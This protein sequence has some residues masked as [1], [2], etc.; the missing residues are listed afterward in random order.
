MFHNL[1]LCLKAWVQSHN[2]SLNGHGF[3]LMT[4]YHEL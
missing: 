2:I 3:F 1:E 4:N